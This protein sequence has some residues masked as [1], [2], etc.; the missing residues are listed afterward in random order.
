MAVGATTLMIAAAAAFWGHETK[1]S[2]EETHIEHNHD[3]ETPES[4]FISQKDLEANEIE[5]ANA[6]PGSLQKI[7]RAPANII[8]HNDRIAHVLP[9][10]VGNARKAYKN[11]GEQVQAGELLATLE[12]REMAEAKADFLAAS[13]KYLLTEMTYQREKNLREKNITSEQDFQNARHAVEEARIQ[14]ELTRQ[15][16]QALGLT[17]NEIVSLPEAPPSLLRVYELRA[18]ISGKVISRH[19]NPGELMN[20]DHEAFVIADLGKVWADI[21]IFPQ[22]LSYIKEGQEISIDCKDGKTTKAKLF[23]VSPVL[24]EDTRTAKAIAEID[25]ENGKFAPGSFAC[26]S[27]ITEET[28][29]AIMIPKAALQEIDG[30]ETVFIKEGENFTPRVVKLGRSDEDHVEVLSGLQPG[31]TYAS[32][33]TFLLKAELKK[34]EA[35]HMD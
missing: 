29:V 19:F 33:N 15:K 6:G 16:L 22:D 9:K 14:L 5:T 8:L 35:E 7:V 4:V 3:H 28:P 11:L 2:Q 13:K 30:Q 17:E 20:L 1:K 23:Y 18:P 24:S 31:E 26:A 10:V 12:S 34:S 25:N 21:T 32:K 27:M